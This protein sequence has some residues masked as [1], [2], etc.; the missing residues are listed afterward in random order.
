VT[1][2]AAEPLDAVQNSRPH[3]VSNKQVD[4]RRAMPK[5]Q[6]ISKEENQSQ[7]NRKVFIGGIPSS[8]TDNDVKEYCSKFGE[9]ENIYVNRKQDR[10][11][12]FATFVDHDNAD[13]MILQDDHEIHGSKIQVRKAINKKAQQNSMNN[14]ANGSFGSPYGQM[15]PNMPQYGGYQQG[16]MGGDSRPQYGGYQMQQRPQFSQG[17]A[18]NSSAGFNGQG[19]G[20]AAQPYMAGGYQAPYMQQ[21]QYGSTPSQYGARPSGGAAVP[22]MGSYQYSATQAYNP[23]K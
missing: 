4:T 6:V 14:S 8:A 1:Y 18:P 13:K 15:P 3:T 19:R 9:I 10:H 5:E 20:A 23:N 17:S 21:G 12:G 7:N 22:S 16:Y 11:Y 2:D